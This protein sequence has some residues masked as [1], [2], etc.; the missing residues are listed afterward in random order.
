MGSV[1]KIERRLD[2]LLGKVTG[3]RPRPVTDGFVVGSP[4]ELTMAFVA[5]SFRGVREADEC[6]GPDVTTFCL[7]AVE[8]LARNVGDKSGGRQVESRRSQKRMREHDA[9]GA[10]LHCADRSQFIESRLGTNQ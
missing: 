9:A 2:Q 8:H 6:A 10:A 3:S 7:Q 1:R 5:G 4:H